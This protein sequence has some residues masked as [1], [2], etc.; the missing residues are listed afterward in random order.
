MNKNQVSG[1][2]DE[3]LGKTKEIAGKVVGDRKM[4]EKGRVEKR[5]G[6]EEAKRGDLRSEA[7][8]ERDSK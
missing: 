3:A 1:R 2:K 8:K 4:E 5:D 7:K 6:K